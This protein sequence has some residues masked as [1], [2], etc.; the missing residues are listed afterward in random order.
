[1][2]AKLTDKDTSICYVCGVENPF[3]L[4]V[5]FTRDGDSGSRASYVVRP[6]HVG[7]PGLLH[8]GVLFTLMD[9]AVAWA[10][11]YSGFRAVT[12]KAET[13]FRV[14][15]QVGASL[16]ITGSVVERARRLV[17]VRA[18]IQRDD[19]GHEKVADMVATMYLLDD[20]A[21]GPG[22]KPEN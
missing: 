11:Y 14:P 9:E 17:R 22:I 2:S 20:A 18:E 15:I 10:V 13:R 6:E 3:G 4:H 21:F 8:G 19:N 16:V 12:A 7:W 5:P 1:V